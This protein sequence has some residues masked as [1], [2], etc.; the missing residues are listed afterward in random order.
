MSQTITITVEGDEVSI[1]QVTTMANNTVK[2]T[3]GG[4]YVEFVVR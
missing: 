3:L 2:L 1:Q 4:D